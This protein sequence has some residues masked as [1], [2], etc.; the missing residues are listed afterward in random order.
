MAPAVCFIALSGLLLCFWHLAG[1]Q[2]VEAFRLLMNS[3][4]VKAVSVSLSLMRSVLNNFL[5]SAEYI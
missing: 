3:L 1:V 2:R 5:Y 4:A